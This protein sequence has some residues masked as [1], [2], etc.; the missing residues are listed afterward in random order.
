VLDETDPSITCPDNIEVEC[1]DE[2][3]DP[4]ADLDAFLAAGGTVSDNCDENLEFTLLSNTSDGESCPEVITR[5]YQVTDDCGN[6]QT[7]TQLVTVLDETDPSITCPDNIEVECS[8]EVPDPY[9]DLDAFLAAGGT[10]SDNCD[11]NLEFTLLSNTSDG[12]SCPEVITRVYQVTDDCGNSQTCTQLVTVLDE[13]DPSIT[14][15]DNIEV[16]CSDEVPDPYADLD[17]FLAA[18]G[19]VSDNC[20]ENLEFTLLSN[21]SDGESCPEVIT[22]VYQVTDDCGNSQTCTQ[23]VT[24]L[25]ETDPS[26]TCPDNIEV[27]CSDE[28]P[29]PYADLDAFLAA[30]GTVS[31]NCDENLEFTLLSNTS[32]GESCP[33]VITRVYQVTDDCGNS[34]TCTQL[35]TVLDETDPSITCPD[36]IEVECSDEVPDPY[37]DLDAFLAAGGTVSDNCDENLEFTLLS[38]TSDGESCP[39]VITRVYQVTD[40]CGN[41]QTCTQLVTVLDETDPSITCPDNIEVECSDEVPDPYADLDAFLAAGG[42]VSDNCDENLEF[43]LLSNTSDGESCPE[44]ITRVYQVTDDCG[45][46][47]TCT[48]L[49][50]VLD[51]TDPSITC[52]D[53]IEVECSDEVPDPYAD[54]DAF[55][56]AGGTVS[57][58]CDE[59]LEFT[60]LSNTSDGESCPEVI[61]RVYQVTDDC[62][63]SQTCTQLVTVLDETDPSITCPDNIEVECSDEVPDP[64]ADLDAFLAA[65]G[66][67]SDNCDE[68]LEFTLLSNTSDGESCPEVI[69]RVYQVTDDCGNSQTCTQLV[70]V[71]DETD[72]SITCPDDIEIECGEDVPDPYEDLD[73]FL[74]AGGT[75]SDNCDEELTFELV[76]STSDEESCPETITRIYQVTDDCGNSQTCTQLVTIVDTTAPTIECPPDVFKNCGECS[77]DL[78]DTG[79]PTVSDICDPD[80]TVT[81][82]DKFADGTLVPEDFDVTSCPWTIFRTFTATDACTNKATC[83]QKITCTPNVQIYVTD[84]ALCTYDRDPSTECRDFRLI[85]STKGL[86][87][88]NPGQTYFNVYYQ[89]TPGTEVTINLIIP[90]PY[91]TQGA[92]PIHAYDDVT[93]TGELPELCLT[94]GNEIYSGTNQI[95]LAD[96][97]GDHTYVPNDDTVTIP[98]TLTVPATGFIYLN[99]HLDYGLK[100]GPTIYTKDDNNSAVGGGMTILDHGTYTFCID[101]DLCDSICNINEIKKNVGVAG[102]AAKKYITFTGVSALACLDAGYIVELRNSNKALLATTKTDIDGYYTVPFK[103]TGKAATVYVILKSKDGK[104]TLQTKSFTLKAN[105]FVIQDFAL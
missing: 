93:F 85:F 59:N 52:P 8:D 75:V 18:G 7:C 2:V 77:L 43:T 41:S 31:D 97:T 90:Y 88:S 72:P 1:S 61:T 54:L 48:Q 36:N 65:G 22:R 63:N 24:V 95:T 94:P 79:V 20:D 89:G 66:T 57:D 50:T 9:A 34:Q 25:D 11:E 55:L 32:D 98:V 68:N 37:A 40:D 100:K 56:A 81:Y 12:E 60:L 10:V 101:D 6:S 83:E 23:L 58:N 26:I 76:S 46:S 73:A 74:T 19:T 14:C 3:P 91:V 15:P 70:T 13:T 45:N 102:L 96:Y 49:V 92:R 84:S 69:T 28:V 103:W 44:V 30:G 35:V 27:E 78:E 39:E 104:T 87:A 53:N 33:E 5:V 71:L 17:A 62:G 21:T 105:G 67:V 82:V 64:Y 51:E 4:Y 42:T 47:Q 16:E 99:I 80:P 38:N 86:T 29:D